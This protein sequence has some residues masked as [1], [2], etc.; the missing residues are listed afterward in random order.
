VVRIGRESA[1]IDWRPFLG[2]GA[3]SGREGSISDFAL[4]EEVLEDAWSRVMP[5]LEREW[6]ETLLPAVNVKD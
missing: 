2:G 4:A 5:Y 3:A 6:Q 1:Y